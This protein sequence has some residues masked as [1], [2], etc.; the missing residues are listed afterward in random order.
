MAIL[1][2]IVLLLFLAVKW[3]YSSCPDARLVHPCQC[4]SEDNVVSM[5]CSNLLSVDQL[6]KIFESSFPQNE[7][8]QLVVK[9]SQLGNIGANIFA[10]K[11]FTIILFQV[12]CL[13][14]PLLII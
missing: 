6:K 1:S 11:S 13:D 8:R 3:C 12:N 4:Q 9:H 10:D 5:A 2:D 14:I 7:L